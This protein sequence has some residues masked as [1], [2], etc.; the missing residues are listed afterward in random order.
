MSDTRELLRPGVE[1]F[2]P[3]PDAFERVLVRRDR[4][5]R[6][7]RMAAGIVGIAVFVIAATGLLRLIGSEPTPAVPQP[8]QPRNGRWVVFSA[9]HLD[10]S[11]DAQRASRGRNF[12][13]YVAG[14]DG[15]ARL[16]VG[17]EGDSTTRACP[18]F[19]PDGSLLA[20]GEKRAAS[21]GGTIVVTR[22][23]SSGELHGP[24]IRIPAP[25]PAYFPP[26]CPTWAPVGQRLAVF[27]PR[28][29]VLFA[30][31]DG[32]T[33][34]VRIDGVHRLDEVAGLQWSPDGS[35]VAVLPMASYPG[36][37]TLWIVPADGGAPR[38]LTGFD[39]GEVPNTVAWTPDARSVVV[40]GSTGLSPVGGLSGVSPFV[41]VVD[42]AT[43]VASDVPLPDAWDGS[44][45]L[46][47]VA[48]GTDRFLALRAAAT[49]WLPP[50]WLDLQGNVTPIRD[51][52]YEPF[53]YISLSPDGAQMLFVTY[54]PTLPSQ[55]QAL[56]A[57]PLDGGEPTR[58]SPWTPNGFGD[59]YSTFAWQPR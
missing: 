55:G 28:Q 54:D 39:T 19:S 33:S 43:G 7:R 50:E 38:P 41:K 4:K 9:L 57:V 32:T 17:T 6:N 18:A 36:S 58:L 35:Q 24:E 23:T 45:Y 8:T 34:L 31:A 16:L 40:G 21:I 29:G 46:Q 56:V 14:P 59:N 20:Y 25:T 3:T 52:E 2:E 37:L 47:T 44:F 27:V 10:P 51:L 22:F 42:V 5:R 30:E 15:T 26:P 13:L 11:P 48:T 53:S 12:K 1:G 49:G